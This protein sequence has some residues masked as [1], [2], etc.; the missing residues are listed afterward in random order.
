LLL[1]S[2]AFVHEKAID[3]LVNFMDTHPEAGAAG[4]RLFYEDGALQRSC[5]SFPTLF[6]ELCIALWLDRLFSTHPLF[7]KYQMTYWDMNDTR[8]VD[9]LLGACLM[10]RRE[11]IKKIGLFD[12]Q[13]FMYSEEVDLC[14]RLKR[15]G[16]KIYFVSDSE[17]THVWGGSAR[18]V[19]VESFLRLYKS[20]VLFFRK[21]YGIFTTWLYKGLLLVS[22]ILRIIAGFTVIIKRDEDRERRFRN[23]WL[24]FQYVWSF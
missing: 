7:G 2:D 15:A 21:H 22:S 5:T 18:K 3:Q 14:F 20:R 9:A 23:Y 6:T 4:C 19:Q 1:N 16:W 12:E 17:A 11:A 8:E 10:L 13:F 24:L